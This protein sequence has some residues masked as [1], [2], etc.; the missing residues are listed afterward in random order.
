MRMGV[1]LAAGLIAGALASAPAQAKLPREPGRNARNDIAAI[2]RV[3]NR[4]IAKLDSGA[5][6]DPPALGKTIKR[7]I[8]LKDNELMRH[9]LPAISGVNFTLLF[10]AVWF[11]DRHIVDAQGLVNPS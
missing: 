2:D 3:L 4:E 7:L 1:L 6:I 11:A 10:H 5:A 8:D 9:D